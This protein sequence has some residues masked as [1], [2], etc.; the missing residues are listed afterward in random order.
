MIKSE[1]WTNKN[2]KQWLHFI[3]NSGFH[4]N[5]VFTTDRII[6]QRNNISFLWISA[7]FSSLVLSFYKVILLFQLFPQLW[8]Q[9]VDRAA[10]TSG[11]LLLLHSLG[12][13]LRDHNA[14]GLQDRCLRHKHCWR[15]G[16]ERGLWGNMIFCNVTDY[17]SDKLVTGTNTFPKKWVYASITTSTI[18]LTTVKLKNHQAKGKYSKNSTN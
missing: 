4:W 17:E 18:Y 3:G 14:E 6:Y 9:K 15:P 7:L 10:G 13:S 11:I 1:R 8:T 16:E 12:F 2:L 5:L